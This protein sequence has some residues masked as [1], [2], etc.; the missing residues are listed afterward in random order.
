MNVFRLIDREL[1]I[2]KRKFLSFAGISGFANAAIL[3]VINVSAEH[4]S[5]KEDTIY[6]LA[7][8]IVVSAMYAVAQKQLMMEATTH[9]EKSINSLRIKL[10][11]DI[12]H[13]ELSTI[14][15]I[16][17]EKIYTIV[18][19]ELQTMS[20][21]SALFVICGQAAILLF[22]TILYVAWLSPVAFFLTFIFLAI[23]SGWHILRSKE[24]KEKLKQAFDIE[25]VLVTRLSD[26]LGGFKEVKL[27]SDRS[28][29]LEKRILDLSDDVTE[30]KIST[31]KIY[32]V[33]FVISQLTFF[34]LTGAMVFLVPIL[35]SVYPDV[36]MKVTTASLFLIGPI[37]NIVGGVPIFSNANAAIQNVLELE[38][39]LQ[40][41]KS[42]FIPENPTDNFADGFNKIE[43]TGLYFS[44]SNGDDE[45]PFTVGPVNLVIN[46]GETIFIT[47]GNG[48]GKT[49]F[50]R[51]MT[52]LYQAS[53]GM[54]KVDGRII[55]K[56]N[57]MAYRNLFSSV[58]A[59]FHLFQEIYGI[60][61]EDEA[62]YSEWLEY[63]GMSHKVK[64]RDKQF[65]TIKLSTG[66]RKRLALMVSA[67]EN[68]PICIFDEWA[69]DQ[70]PTFREKF[71]SEILPRLKANHQTVIAVT[72]DDMYFD[73]ADR[74]LK[75]VDGQIIEHH[76]H[77]ESPL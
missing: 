22:F 57:C 47:G 2:N 54:I 58:F 33:D 71:Y 56:N 46:R 49:T 50:M 24:V 60:S 14:E 1:K 21:A 74:Q 31:Q 48:S 20:Q 41:G 16:G 68:R 10:V 53:G 63:I 42:A 67:L 12:L 55:D 37:S 35:S 9:V 52:T 29:E 3:A 51:L 17:K 19:K 11:K 66:Q 30:T 6:Y 62:V 75:M 72:H 70:D 34:I 36:V 15:T 43:M 26:L 65:S 8:F 27:N 73:R 39:M 13:S 61:E 18:S 76:S 5:N 25:N 45:K 4:V 23:G 40:D 7:L 59:D 28:S 44:H 64:I 32:A 77:M 69:A 38:Q